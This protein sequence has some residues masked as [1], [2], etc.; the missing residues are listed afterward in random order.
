MPENAGFRIRGRRLS[1]ICPLAHPPPPHPTAPAAELCE[2]RRREQLR[3]TA[4]TDVIHAQR[5][6]F[7]RNAQFCEFCTTLCFMRRIV[8]IGI[9]FPAA[10]RFTQT[11]MHI[12]WE[13]FP[14]GPND[15][16]EDLHV[17]LSRKG[18]ILIGARAFER[19]GSPDAVVL[20]HD[21]ANALIGIVPAHPNTRNAYP[22]KTKPGCRHRILRA[23]RFCR[24]H[25]IH[26]DRTI[27]FTNARI[28]K[29]TLMLNVRATVAVGKTRSIEESALDTCNG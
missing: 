14:F 13:E 3:A 1:R 16:N 26:T 28:D 24:H 4:E 6:V 9:S 25:N 19:L 20:L 10:T 5:A 22:L 2:K 8:R 11:R 18:E 17:T 29:G 7:M 12:Q 21:R 23:N 15:K 27:A